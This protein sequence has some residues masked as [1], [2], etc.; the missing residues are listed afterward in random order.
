VRLRIASPSN[1]VRSRQS[2]VLRQMQGLG[3]QTVKIL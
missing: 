1:Y 3:I 2:F